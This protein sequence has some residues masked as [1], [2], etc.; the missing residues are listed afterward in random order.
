[1]DSLPS[2]R[3]LP[4]LPGTFLLTLAA[5][6]AAIILATDTLRTVLAVGAM[7]ALGL[8]GGL[9][10]YRRSLD[11]ARRFG[12]PR[13]RAPYAP[14]ANPYEPTDYL[15]AVPRPTLP[16]RWPRLRALTR[17]A[18]L[19]GVGLAFCFHYKIASDLLSARP[20]AD[21]P[22]VIS[23]TVLALGFAVGLAARPYALRPSRPAWM[24]WA[25][26]AVIITEWLT[27]FM[28]FTATFD[29][30][31]RSAIAP[32]VVALGAVVPLADMARELMERRY[33]AQLAGITIAGPSSR[34]SRLRALWRSGGGRF[35]IGALGLVALAAYIFL[36]AP[37]LN[38][39][40]LVVRV[41]PIILAVGCV[42]IPRGKAEESSATLA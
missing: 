13:Q 42:L 22:S 38:G 32:A 28:L 16:T 17:A 21:L 19:L 14:P 33:S 36:T 27:L 35:A 31:Y 18:P 9:F 29:G 37:H 12:R 24:V 20:A 1:M 25:A 23:V 40:S 2:V 7:I 39:P 15:P 30:S 11:N 4:W 6:I 3:R 26:L 41:W 5:M 10:V 8:L 34:P